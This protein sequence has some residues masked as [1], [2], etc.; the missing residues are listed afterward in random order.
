M[1]RIHFA[2]ITNQKKGSAADISRRHTEND[3]R[4]VPVY[5]ILLYKSFYL[6]ERGM[7]ITDHRVHT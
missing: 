1:L 2:N 6:Y 4:N 7:S 3:W 5:C